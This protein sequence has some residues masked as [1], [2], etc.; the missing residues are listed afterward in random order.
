MNNSMSL[1]WKHFLLM[2]TQSQEHWTGS[3]RKNVIPTQPLKV[4]CPF[5]AFLD[6]PGNKRGIGHYVLSRLQ[7]IKC[8]PEHDKLFYLDNEGDERCIHS[9]AFCDFRFPSTLLS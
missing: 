7:Y 6:L 9:F 2:Q 8:W 5:W 1:L 3:L 4:T